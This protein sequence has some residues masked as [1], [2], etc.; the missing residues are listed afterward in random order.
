MLHAHDGAVGGLFVMFLMIFL[1][2]NVYYKIVDLYEQWFDENLKRLF[3]SVYIPLI[4]S[5]MA[6]S[7]QVAGCLTTVSSDKQLKVWDYQDNS[8]K[9]VMSRDMKMVN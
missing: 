2:C 4:L 1:F 8:P 5:G 7:T 6:L 3:F 9:C